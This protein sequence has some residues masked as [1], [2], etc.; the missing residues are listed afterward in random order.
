MSETKNT[1]SDFA[2]RMKPCE[3]EGNDEPMQFNI[4][5]EEDPEVD[6]TEH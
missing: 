5:T 2:I 6:R 1:E 3:I 4:Y